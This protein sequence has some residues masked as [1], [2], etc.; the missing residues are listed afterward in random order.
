MVSV[1]DI[2]WPEHGPVT[3]YSTLYTPEEKGRK[4]KNLL[5][6]ALKIFFRVSI[7]PR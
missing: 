1:F 5:C 3:L 7:Y 6:R 4:T 2:Y